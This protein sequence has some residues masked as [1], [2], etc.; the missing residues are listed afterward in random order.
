MELPTVGLA[1]GIHGAWLALTGLGNGLPWWALAPLGG[2][3]VA[4]HGSLQHETIHGHPSGSRRLNSAL[5]SVP[6]SLWLPYGIYREQHLQHH[7]SKNLTDP[8]EDPESFYVTSETWAKAGMFERTFLQLQ[9]TLLGRVLLGPI[10]VVLRFLGNEIATMLKGDFRHARAWGLHLVAMALML[11]W[12]LGVGH[13]SIAKYLLCFVYPGVGLTLLRSFA[14]H[15]PAEDPAQR[16][17]IVES[18]LLGILFLNNNLHVLHHDSPEVPWY[19]L[20]AQY[21]E[22]REAL[23]ASG[24]VA[25]PG[26]G[27]LFR[28]FAFRV[29]DSPVHPLR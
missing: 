20:P 1:L 8:L 13:M 25:V 26:Y 16:V 21:Q 24:R 18:R 14:E 28:A 19:E 5:G 17:A 6:L 15:T 4:W 22:R 3:L 11:T 10:R 12:V 29:K 23:A 9:M 2:L 27:H 7:R